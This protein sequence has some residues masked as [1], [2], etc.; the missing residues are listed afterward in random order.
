MVVCSCDWLLSCVFT[1]A[2]NY[3]YICS[4]VLPPCRQHEVQ[5]PVPPPRVKL[6]DIPMTST[7]KDEESESSSTDESTT[8]VGHGGDSDSSTPASLPPLDSMTIIA[9]LL[10]ELWSLQKKRCDVEIKARLTQKNRHLVNA[11]YSFTKYKGLLISTLASGPGRAKAAKSSLNTGFVTAY[12]FTKVTDFPKVSVKTTS[13]GESEI[14]G[15]GPEGSSSAAAIPPAA[16]KLRLGATLG[17]WLNS[18]A[19]YVA[20]LPPPQAQSQ[21]RTQTPEHSSGSNDGVDIEIDMSSGQTHS[22]SAATKRQPVFSLSS[23]PIVMFWC[24]CLVTS[25]PGTIYITVDHLY[26]QYG[27]AFLHQSKEVYPLVSIDNCQEDPTANVPT[28]KISLGGKRHQLS[29]TPIGVE[30][31]VLRTVLYDILN[32]NTHHE[33]KTRNKK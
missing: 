12:M 17:S 18:A 21:T 19:A 33:S 32:Y 11:S 23:P 20:P 24:S 9:K 28:L 8:A 14:A 5:L 27:F 25:T 6:A 1:I 2:D 7:F 29:I 31:S 26:V 4:F 30:C 15:S 10:K 22:S 13:S 3:N 16:P